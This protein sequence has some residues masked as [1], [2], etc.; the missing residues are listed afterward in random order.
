MDAVR[1]APKLT[2]RK[3]FC[4]KNRTAEFAIAA[5]APELLK[6]FSADALDPI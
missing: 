4:G 3:I 1:D 5:P 6:R 2:V